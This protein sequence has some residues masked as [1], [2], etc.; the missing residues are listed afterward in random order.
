MCVRSKLGRALVTGWRHYGL[1]VVDGKL[2][3][4]IDRFLRHRDTVKIS[5]SLGFHWKT[6]RSS[7]EVLRAHSQH[8]AKVLR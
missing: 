1:N 6:H 8:R 2:R 3:T 4:T 5:T 7:E